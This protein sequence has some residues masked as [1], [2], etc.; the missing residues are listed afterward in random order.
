MT[1]ESAIE[2]NGLTKRYGELSVL[3]GVD[4]RV[5]RGSVFALL[6]PNGAGKTT[7]VRILATLARADAGTVRVAGHDVAHETHLVRRAISLTGQYAAIDGLLTAEESL[8][9]MGRLSGL[10]RGQ[11]RERAG[12]LLERFELTAARD[13]RVATYSGG[14]RRKLDLAVGLVG[15]PEVVFLDEPTTGLDPRSR[16]ELW[17]VVAELAETGVTVFLTTQYL[18]EAD[19]L[20]DRVAVL[21]TGRIVA[22][23]TARELKARV[24]G[25]RLDLVLADSHAY[26]TLRRALGARAVH[27]DQDTLTLGLATDGTAAHVRALLNSL[28]PDQHGIASVSV[29]TATLDDVFLALTGHSRQAEG[30]GHADASHREATQPTTNQ[31]RQEPA[32]V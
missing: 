8:R 32:D 5:A 16:Q 7:T 12:E 21:D 18:E 26:E 30:P 11:A 4:L 31:P 28:D 13:R 22:E 3:R 20:A 6:G 25:A 15:R 27:A 24:A 29:H 10:T 19:Q 14:M 9:M 17:R 2:A 23:G 1:N